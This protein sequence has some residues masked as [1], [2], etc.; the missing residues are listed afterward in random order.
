MQNSLYNFIPTFSLQPNRIVAYNTVQKFNSYKK[1]YENVSKGAKTLFD[2][3]SGTFIKNP[4]IRKPHNFTISD[5]AYRTLQSK[6]NWLYYLAKSKTVK[7]HKNVIIYNHKISFITLTL[8]SKQKSCTSDITSR[9]LNQFLTEIRG[10]FGMENYVWRLE[11]Q[12][13]GNVHYHLVTDT[14]VPYGSIRN[15]WNRTIEKDGYVSD[16]QSKMK[17]MSLMEYHNLYNYG[18]KVTFSENAKRYAKG[19]AENWSNPP[20]VDVKSVVSNKAIAGYL[21]KYFAKDSKN[22]VICNEFDNP[23][24][25]K[26]L[27]LWFCSRS[28]SKLNKISEYIEAYE[29]KIF[30][31]I[32][33]SKTIDKFKTKYA[34]IINFDI[35]TMVGNARKWIDYILK[36]YAFE[37]SYKPWVPLQL[38][39]GNYM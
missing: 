30:D 6:I 32:Q 18:N 38:R 8:P 12:K 2:F 35:C 10:R 7:T 27:R 33:H 37:L 36:S 11:F 29:H 24:N 14:Y 3:E 39:L 13:N 9:L 23:E 21:S 4:L 5:N 25:S 34:T 1:E 26:S 15:I 19:A 31:I 22:Q 16:Y 20:T 17:S 28:L